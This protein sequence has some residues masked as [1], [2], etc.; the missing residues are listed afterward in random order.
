MR[1]ADFQI[2]QFPEEEH[3]ARKSPA[4]HDDPEQSRRFIEV[5][6]EVG[7]TEEATDF[8]QVLGKVA[9]SPVKRPA[10]KKKSQSPRKR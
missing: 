4:P 2:N 5:A 1:Y 3:L 8:D 9:E 6:K 10:P 7:A